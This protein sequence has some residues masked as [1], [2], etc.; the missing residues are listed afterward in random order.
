MWDSEVRL[1]F[2][3]HCC[4]FELAWCM[5]WQVSD[6][7]RLERA[8]AYHGVSVGFKYSGKEGPGRLLYIM[9]AEGK[10]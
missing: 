10:E 6:S 5:G 1:K 2:L 4:R 3:V 9:D 8:C 7:G